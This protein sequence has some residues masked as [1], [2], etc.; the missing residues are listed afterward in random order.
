V[1]GAMLAGLPAHVVDRLLARHLPV[2]MQ[3]FS[4]RQRRE[5]EAAQRQLREAA[6]YWTARTA[7]GGTAAGIGAPVVADSEGH[8]MDVAQA[9]GLLGVEVRRVRQLAAT[10]QAHGLARKVGQSWLLDATT[11]LAY[12]DEQRRK[13]A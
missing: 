10:W 9:A 4:P 12:R 6:D 1:I 2:L 13:R 5:M 3:G 11:V 7:A 8:E